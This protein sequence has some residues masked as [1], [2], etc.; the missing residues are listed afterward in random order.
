MATN[1]TIEVYLNK[2]DKFIEG[3]EKL[4]K[5]LIDLEDRI[6]VKKSHIFL[7]GVTFVILGLG[8]GYA[9]QLLCNAIGFLYPSYASIKAIESSHKEDDT[10]WL[11][12][13]VVFATFSMLESFS[14]LIIGWMPFY[15]L[16]KCFF[17]VW[18]MSP[19]NG[20]GI[21]Y[22][23]VILPIFRENEAKIDEV[24]NQGKEKL[25][26]LTEKTTSI[27]EDKKAS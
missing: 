13:W 11:I 7:L 25:V 5:I 8:S 12:Y 6:K 2:V 22:R 3:H 17:L 16:C 20:S 23:T 27:L 14:D 15:W 9:G 19:M 26:E 10:K 4:D 24:V 1:T 18:C 21:V